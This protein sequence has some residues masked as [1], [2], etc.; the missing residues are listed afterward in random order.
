MT[1]SMKTEHKANHTVPI[2]VRQ[3]SYRDVILPIESGQRNDRTQTLIAVI[4]QHAR[5]PP[6]P[7]LDSSGIQ[8]NHS[9]QD[10]QATNKPS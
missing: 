5:K 1:K 8:S 7:H 10:K 2:A 4:A 3:P 6:Q 9:N